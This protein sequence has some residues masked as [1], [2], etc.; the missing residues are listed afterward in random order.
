MIWIGGLVE[1]NLM[2]GNILILG[3]SVY[4]LSL[5]AL[6]LYGFVD[7]YLDVYIVTDRRIVDIRQNGFFK[8]E[9]SEL[10]LREV[11][12]VNAKVIGFFPTVL[13]F[14]EVVIQTAGE[15][16]NFLFNSVPHPYQISKTIMDLHESIINESCDDD[17][18][19]GHKKFSEKELSK[20]RFSEA[21]IASTKEYFK[22]DKEG[23]GDEKTEIEES[24][25]EKIDASSLEDLQE[26]A[27]IHGEQNSLLM[28]SI[29]PDKKEY[30][31]GKEVL[32]EEGKQIILE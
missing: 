10:Y 7:Y 30:G 26:K 19:I 13:H 24:F 4:L 6:L 5:L 11:Q 18:V 15:I 28:E 16:D 17:K 27:M 12:D 14:G 29:K 25:L 22:E 1:I 31:S 2:T 9:I 21:A 8:R 20:G 32:L 3:G 23:K